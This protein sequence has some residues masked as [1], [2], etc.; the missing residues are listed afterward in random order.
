MERLESARLC[1]GRRCCGESGRVCKKL[2]EGVGEDSLNQPVRKR[3]RLALAGL[4]I[5]GENGPSVVI[6][7]A[8]RGELEL[9]GECSAVQ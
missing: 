6:S 7:R 4:S 1:R 9:E 2:G 8:I 3:V 5:G